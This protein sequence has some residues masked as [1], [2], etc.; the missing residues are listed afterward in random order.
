MGRKRNFR[1]YFS[2]SLR[3]KYG[4]KDAEAHVDLMLSV[5]KR[6]F[7]FTEEINI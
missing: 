5:G 6:E 3:Q 4:G 2:P 7:T 1:A